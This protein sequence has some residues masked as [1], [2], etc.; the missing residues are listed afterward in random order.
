MKKLTTEH[1]ILKNW[2]INNFESGR[3]FTI[4]E[5]IE[6]VRYPDGKA[7][8]KLNT[9][10]YSHDKCIKLANMVK[11]LNWATGVERYIPIIKDSRGS[12]KLAESKEE[13]DK[14]IAKERK[15]VEKH[16]QYYNHLTSLAELHDTI[17]F[18]NLANRVLNENELQPV[19]VF[20]R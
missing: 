10:P 17:P 3:Y 6:N 18:I 7:V 1:H 2:L 20:K 13:L 11:E 14:Y 5:I 15:K 12:I 9:N 19:E 16:Y 8:F 4:E